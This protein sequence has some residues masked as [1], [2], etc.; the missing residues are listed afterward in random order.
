MQLK[1]ATHHVR[2]FIS[3][4]ENLGIRIRSSCLFGWTTWLSITLVPSVFPPSML[5]ISSLFLITPSTKR[6][7][8]SLVSISTRFTLPSASSS[9]EATFVASS[10]SFYKFWG[11]PSN[12]NN[13]SRRF[14][15]PFNPSTI[16]YFFSASRDNSTAK[17]FKY[18]PRLNW[19]SR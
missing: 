1:N 8:A 16:F 4:P 12:S 18:V 13:S 17:S 14:S 19:N 10:F 11:C 5:G 15:M 2:Y 7:R 3:S 9:I 6:N